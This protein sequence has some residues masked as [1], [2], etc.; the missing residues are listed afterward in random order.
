MPH[1]LE[2]MIGKLLLQRGWRIALGESCT[3]GL[4]GHRI[5]QVPGSSQYLLGGVIAYSNYAKQTLLRVS[6]QTLAAHGAVSE[7]TALEMAIGARRVLAAEVGLSVT[8]IAG[9][10][11]GTQEKP[12]GLTWFAVST[13]NG[14]RTACNIWPGDREQNKAESAEAALTLLLETLQ[15]ND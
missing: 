5:T 9:P 4:V 2:R 11:G 7:Q 13:P 6:P 14:D 12:V 10:G 3:G 1:S 8:G 15:E